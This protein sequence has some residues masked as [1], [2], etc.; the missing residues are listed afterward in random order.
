[1]ELGHSHWVLF[2][3]QSYVVVMLSVPHL[4]VPPSQDGSVKLFQEP[5]HAEDRQGPQHTEGRSSSCFIP[6][7]IEPSDLTVTR[8]T[9]NVSD[10]AAHDRWVSSERV[11]MVEVKRENKGRGD[12]VGCGMKLLWKVLTTKLPR[13]HFV[14]Q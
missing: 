7:T 3:V 10:L 5:Y 12:S 4:D 6:L 11:S 1:M 8:V 14:G 13:A 9:V 2:V